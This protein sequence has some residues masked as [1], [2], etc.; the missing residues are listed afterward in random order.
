MAKSLPSRVVSETPCRF[1]FQFL[2]VSTS[3]SDQELVN[4]IQQFSRDTDTRFDRL[5]G[6]IGRLEGRITTVEGGITTIEGGITT[7]EGRITTIE[8]RITTIEREIVA[9]GVRL[10]VN[11]HNSIARSFN[12]SITRASSDLH[13]LKTPD[14]NYVLEFP[15]TLGILNTYDVARMDVLLQRF[16]MPVVGDLN[17][18]RQVFRRYIGVGID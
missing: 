15:Q 5:E 4:L 10:S 11:D 12:S 17:H 16:N 18:K 1:G 8:G 7:I 13:I 3:L 2:Q 9:I 6:R 14:D